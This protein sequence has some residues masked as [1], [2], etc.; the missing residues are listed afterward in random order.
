MDILRT[1]ERAVVNGRAFILGL[2]D[3]KAAWL[4]LETKDGALVPTF[5][6]VTLESGDRFNRSN[7]PYIDAAKKILRRL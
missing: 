7:D 1:R 3:N 6:P 2:D 4:C 5:G